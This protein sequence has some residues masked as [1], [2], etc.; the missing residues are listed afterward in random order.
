MKVMLFRKGWDS[1]SRGIPSPIMPDTTLLS[2]PIPT[3]ES[4]LYSD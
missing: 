1:S 3:N 4:V 2:L